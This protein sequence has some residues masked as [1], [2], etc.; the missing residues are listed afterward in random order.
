MTRTEKS[1]PTAAN[2]NVRITLLSL[3]HINQHDSSLRYFFSILH[4][5]REFCQTIGYKTFLGLTVI[6]VGDIP[7]RELGEQWRLWVCLCLCVCLCVCPRSERETAW[8]IWTP[9]LLHIYTLLQSLGMRWPGGQKIKGQGHTVMKTVTADSDCC[10]R[11]ANAAG[12][13]V[14]VVWLFK[15]L[16]MVSTRCSFYGSFMSRISPD[17]TWPDLI[18]ADLISYKLSVL[19]IVTA[20]ANWVVRCE[21]TQF[22]VAAR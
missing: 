12:V 16:L 19:W 3:Q 9:N 14:Y 17:L 1:R 13:G 20:M 22:A 11:C 18:F 10:G 7:S 5:K 8:T 2:D 15:I 21:A 6:H 4:S